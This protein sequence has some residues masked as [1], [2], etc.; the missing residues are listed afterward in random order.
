[1]RAQHKSQ[2]Q[3][4]AWPSWSPVSVPVTRVRGLSVRERHCG[5]WLAGWLLAM[6]WWCVLWSRPS[7]CLYDRRL[8]VHMAAVVACLV[9]GEALQG[10]CAS[11]ADS[12][13]VCEA[14]RMAAVHAERW[15]GEASPLAQAVGARHQR[16]NARI[17]RCLTP[18]ARLSHA[19][20]ATTAPGL[21]NRS[22]VDVSWGVSASLFDSFGTLAVRAVD[23]VDS[24]AGYRQQP[25]RRR[26]R[27]RRRGGAPQ[28]SSATSRPRS[29]EEDVTVNGPGGWSGVSMEQERSTRYSMYLS[30]GVV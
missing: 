20:R 24:T 30:A 16:F 2:G 23:D 6:W 18:S 28:R 15:W 29:G 13:D 17:H 12:V 5:G 11:Y 1:M 25:G 19:A 14:L 22:S 27:R 7:K 4:G 26:R 21:S 9:L 10:V 8:L 3:N